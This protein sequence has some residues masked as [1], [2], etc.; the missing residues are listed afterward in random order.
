MKLAKTLLW[1]GLILSPLA[2]SA[3]PANPDSQL[4]GGAT[5]VLDKS[6][7]AFS[8]PANN[9]SILRRDNFFIGNA[10]FKQPWV[11][12]PSSTSARDGLGPLFNSNSCQGCH[13]KDGKGHPPLTREDSFLSTLVR[14]SIPAETAEQQALVTTL[15]VVPEPNYGDQIQP[16]S[17]PALKGEATPRFEYEE[18]S[19]Q[20][21]DGEGYTLLKP[22]LQLEQL[23]Y[24][25]LHPKVQMSARVAPVM[26]GMGLLEAIPEADLV[27][28]ADPEDKNTDGISGRLNQVWDV[29]AQKTVLGRFGWKANQPTVA[30]QS[31]GAFHG[32]LGITSPHFAAA[33]CMPVQT[34]CL[35]APDGGKPEINQEL[36]DM[37]SFY[38]SL[39]AV[40]ARRDVNDPEVL[41][42]ERLFK[43]ANCSACHI[44]SLKT[45]V[46]PD[47]PELEHQAIQ[48][49]TDLLLHDM[50]E[51]LADQR[52]D[53]LASGSEW[54]T[55]PLWGIGLI[56]TV[57]GHTRFLHDGRARNL[58]EAI[59]WHGGEAEPARQQVLSM[60]KEERAALLRFLNSL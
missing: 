48:P 49:F 21:K 59:L 7:N 8:L 47:F 60:T 46:K 19:G 54:R 5:T 34:D 31:A 16:N 29:S 37:V 55:A 30:Q 44:P 14:V 45:G 3:E 57:N 36:M 6:S 51:G 1:G 42:G 56:E 12:A 25:A 43:Q 41:K 10:F 15:G 20:F 18:I 50:G 17:I 38:A 2:N 52:P 40:P 26:I 33:P 39:L 11:I 9:L 32:D 58:M 22:K 53:F 27:A 28:L 35:K 23:N 24:G 13:V 4:S